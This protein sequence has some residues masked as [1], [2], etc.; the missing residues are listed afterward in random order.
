MYLLRRS[1]GR[2]LK[3]RR[4]YGWVILELLAGLAVVICQD[5]ASIAIRERLACWQ[6]QFQENMISV[7]CYFSG[8]FFAKDRHSSI[9]ISCEEYEAFREEFS[10]RAELYYVQYGSMFLGITPVSLLGMS[11]NEFERL[12]GYPMEDQ[13]W[14]GEDA[15]E[16]L[17]E[18]AVF[19]EG[20]CS[21]QDD[22]ICLYGEDFL[23]EVLRNPANESMIGI[24]SG[25][26]DELQL[27][28]CIL[29]PAGALPS[30]VSASEGG[31]VFHNATLEVGG[32]EFRQAAAGIV[33]A[34]NKS[35][36]PYSY[37]AVDRNLAFR[38]NSG[39]MYD[40]IRL[41][42]WLGRCS[43]LLVAAG[44][45]GILLIHLDERKKD[46]AVSMVTGA[47]RSR[48]MAETAAEIFLVC[49]TGGVLA[50]G[51]AWVIA[52]L[53]SN[54]QYLVSL[55]MHSAGLAL[56]IVAGMTILVWVVIFL[57]GRIKE[58]VAALK[59]IQR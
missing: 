19:G 43:L 11:D 18:A 56:A 3:S 17:E 51:A 58:P 28:Q 14:I 32:K 46:F 23:Y 41:L 9:P 33:E 52:P 1:V 6:R 34:L 5:S 25:A 53:L 7:E 27:S 12:I 47:T 8:D 16:W 2:L 36:K 38:K 50:V 21:L 49:L 22:R 24:S 37:A 59:E 29:I 26:G 13:V 15:L 20:S 39:D 10:G 57:C 31:S 4:Y 44:M 30:A 55:R 35:G 42:G 45:I 54:S 48:L 40:T